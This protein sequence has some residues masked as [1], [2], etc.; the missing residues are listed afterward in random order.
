MVTD[1]KKKR[2]PELFKI[3]PQSYE[4][5]ERTSA[6]ELYDRREKLIIEDHSSTRVKNSTMSK[7]SRPPLVRDKTEPSDL[8][9]SKDPLRANRARDGDAELQKA[10]NIAPSNRS[11][12]QDNYS[13]L[14][15]NRQK[16]PKPQIIPKSMKP[17][18]P[19]KAPGV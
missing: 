11:T 1:R 16:L 5:P 9:E 3:V 13:L 10:L 17:K 6:Q 12:I 14:L 8:E 15:G 2:R 19:K 18:M 4:E 7:Q